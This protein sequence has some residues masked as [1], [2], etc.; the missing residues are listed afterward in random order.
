MNFKINLKESNITR[1]YDTIGTRENWVAACISIMH[2]HAT[3]VWC[4]SYKTSFP[5]SPARTY[6]IHTITSCHHA[7]HGNLHGRQLPV[8]LQTF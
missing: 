4:V 2:V 1:L 8:E 5:D 6:V 3:D 7:L